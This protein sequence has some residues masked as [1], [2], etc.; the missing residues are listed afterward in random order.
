[1]ITVG[2]PTGL[3]LGE[4]MALRWVDV[5]LEGAGAFDRAAG[6]FSRAG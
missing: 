1:M 4:L 3:R 2:L 5:D 6:G